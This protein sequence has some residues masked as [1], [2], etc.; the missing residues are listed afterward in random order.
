LVGALIDD[1]HSSCSYNISSVT[2]VDAP[3]F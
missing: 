1:I 2:H 3:S